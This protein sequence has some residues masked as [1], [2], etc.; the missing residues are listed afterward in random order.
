MARLYAAARLLV[1][2]FQPSFKLKEKRR[3]GAKIIKRY[4]PPATPYERAL[5]HP[6]LPSAVKRRLRQT[7]R[8][9][10]P[11]Q[12]LATIRTA[13]EELGERIGK[14][15]LAKVPTVS[16]ADPLSFARS[17]GTAAKPPKCGR[18][19]AGRNGDTKSAFACP[20]S[21]IPISRPSRTG[22]PSSRSSLHWPSWAGSP[23]SI[24]RCSATSSIR[25]FSACFGPS[26]G[27]WRR[28]PSYPC[29]WMKYGPRLWTALRVMST[30]PR[31]Q[32][33]HRAGRGSRPVW[34]RV[35]RPSSR[36]TLLPEAIRGVKFERRLTYEGTTLRDHLGLQRPKNVFFES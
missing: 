30:P 2:F 24:L 13:Q 15:G 25:S 27:R 19:T 34:G 11:I 32:P 4:H 6:K 16:P 20:R 35:R 17:L 33:L 31:P 36:V 18:R 14:R 1:N 8:T 26:G 3:E 10:D 29:P 21:S 7:Y 22:S 5:G 28:Q 9:L 12:L 23:R